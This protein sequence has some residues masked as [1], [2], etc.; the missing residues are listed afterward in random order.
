MLLALAEQCIA[1]GC[2]K[3]VFI[4]IKRTG[5]WGLWP[6]PPFVIS[7]SLSGCRGCWG[8][9]PH[10]ASGNRELD[11]YNTHVTANSSGAH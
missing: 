10:A 11:N 7:P 6:C 3:A 2:L 4:F 8:A 9:T 1:E 5:N